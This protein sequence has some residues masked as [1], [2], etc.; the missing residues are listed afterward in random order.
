MGRKVMVGWMDIADYWV[1]IAVVRD[2]R[3]VAVMDEA[4]LAMG[5][6]K[7]W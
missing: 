4:I 3:V 7:R 1:G 6:Q 2:R 5:K